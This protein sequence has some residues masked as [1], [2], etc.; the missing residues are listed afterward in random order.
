MGFYLPNSLIDLNADA[1]NS[2]HCEFTFVSCAHYTQPACVRSAVRLIQD[3]ERDKR[4]GC[5]SSR[6][7]GG[8]NN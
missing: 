7:K 5:Q 6:V 4:R 8:V 2:E 1:H 3:L